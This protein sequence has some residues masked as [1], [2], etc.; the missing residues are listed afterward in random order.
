MVITTEKP[1]IYVACL[2]SYNNGN[3]YGE[4]IDCIDLDHINSKIEEMLENS[5]EEDAEE[6][7]I[8]DF[9]NWHGIELNEYESLEKIAELAAL[10][11]KHGKPFAL[12]YT[13]HWGNITADEFLEKYQGE[14][15]SEEDFVRVRYEDDG[16]LQRLKDIGF[17]EAYIDFQAIARDWFCGSYFSI[18]EGGKNHIFS[19]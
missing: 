8:H 18:Q 16:T 11:S 19:S 12:F 3:L 2:A 9:E 10:V 6:W 13:Y 17:L 1:R 5:P 7:A 15:E 4:W 14:F